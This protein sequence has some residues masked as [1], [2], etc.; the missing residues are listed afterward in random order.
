MVRIHQPRL[1]DNILEGLEETKPKIRC[2]PQRRSGIQ[3]SE[4]NCPTRSRAS[5]VPAHQSKRLENRSSGKRNRM[6]GDSQRIS[7]HYARGC[8]GAVLTDSIVHPLATRYTDKITLAR[9]I[10]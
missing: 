6:A 1:F 10:T 5:N 2:E 9:A 7:W 3:F 4:S 8:F